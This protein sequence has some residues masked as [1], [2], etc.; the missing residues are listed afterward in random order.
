MKAD[1]LAGLR[2]DRAAKR[3]VA[4]LT[5][6]KSGDQ[7]LFYPSDKE[8][9]NKPT[10]EFQEAILEAFRDD[11]S[12][13]VETA[14]GPVFVHVHNPPMKLAIIGAVHIARPLSRVAA[15]AGYAVT[16]IDPRQAFAS[17]ARFADVAVSRDWPDAALTALAPDARTAVVMLSH[18][19]KL[20][21]PAL[22][23]ALRSPAFYVGALGSTRTHAARAKRLAERGLDAAAIG[24]IHGPIGLAIGARSPAEIAIA[25]MAE[26]TQALR[27]G[28]AAKAAA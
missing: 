7:R 18:D 10:I 17:D 8:Q 19:P 14:E 4:L 20:D 13:R 16:V 22:E 6:L 3:P 12:R 23:V 24:R 26:V 28:E 9:D 27:Q 15:L 5:N 2:A 21:D 1:I 11:R 25:I